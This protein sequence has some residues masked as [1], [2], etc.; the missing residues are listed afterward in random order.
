MAPIWSAIGLLQNKS[1][2]WCLWMNELLRACLELGLLYFCLH[3][4]SLTAVFKSRVSVSIPRPESSES[5]NPEHWSQYSEF[6]ILGSVFQVFITSLLSLCNSLP[7][8]SHSNTH[9]HTH[10]DKVFNGWRHN[11]WSPL[12]PTRSPGSFQLQRNWDCLYRMF[13]T[14]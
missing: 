14:T 2:L 1:F 9:S 10:T 8:F 7:I 4:N 13:S 5:I 11:V 12:F 6:L 3:N